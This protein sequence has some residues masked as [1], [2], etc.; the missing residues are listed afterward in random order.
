MVFRSRN[1]AV[2]YRGHA[3][4][5]NEKREFTTS[6]ILFGVEQI[7]PLSQIDPNAQKNYRIGHY[8]AVFVWHHKINKIFK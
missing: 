2:N 6:D 5:F 1:S 4:C 3:F 8:R 7:I